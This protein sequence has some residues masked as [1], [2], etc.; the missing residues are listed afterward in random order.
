MFVVFGFFFLSLDFL[1]LLTII[2]SYCLLFFFIGNKKNEIISF[3]SRFFYLRWWFL[4][5]CGCGFVM[6]F[7]SI[8]SWNSYFVCMSTKLAN[9]YIF[10]CYTFVGSGGCLCA[11]FQ[12]KYC[13][14]H[15]RFCKNLVSVTK[16]V[17]R[18]QLR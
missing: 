17:S 14:R 7:Q 13:Q 15:F 9:Y 5:V 18:H 3:V 10:V 16:E 4:F 11:R 1:S 8:Q 12:P 2:L 6:L